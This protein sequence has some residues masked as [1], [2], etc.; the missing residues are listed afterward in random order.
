MSLDFISP[1]EVLEY[2][3]RGNAVVIDI[4]SREAFLKGHI[5]GAVSMP[6][7]TFDEEA[8]I[9]GEYEVLIL[10]CERGSA[11]LFLGRKLSRKGFHVLSIGGG[12]DAWRGPMVY[13][14]AL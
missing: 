8:R 2:I 3:R 12:M 10:C 6:Y 7:D 4:R 9:L 13:G 1:K 14:D 5:P 11:S